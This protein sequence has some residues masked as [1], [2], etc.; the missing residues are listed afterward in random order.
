MYI[1]RHSGIFVGRVEAFPGS[2]PGWIAISDRGI[3]EGYNHG[4]GVEERKAT[5][6]GKEHLI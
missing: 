3:L 1:K 6:E 4:G 2:E 5:Q